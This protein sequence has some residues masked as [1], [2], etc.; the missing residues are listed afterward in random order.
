MDLP[1]LAQ[2]VADFHQLPRGAKLAALLDDGAVLLL[3]G[4][5]LALGMLFMPLGGTANPR[6]SGPVLFL[7][8]FFFGGGEVFGNALG[9]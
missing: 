4:F 8:F 5:C 1:R 3:L 2:H 9:S 6:R 7:M